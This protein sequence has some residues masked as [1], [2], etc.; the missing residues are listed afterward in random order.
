[1]ENTY[2]GMIGQVGDK[3]NAQ[4]DAVEAWG[5]EQAKLQQ[6]QTDFAIEQ[7]EQQ[8]EQA[9]KDYT[10]EQSAAYTDY[11]KQT[12]QHGVNAEQM[13]AA[14]MTGTGYSES[15]KVS[16]Y[17]TYQNRVA[18]ARES[19]N[20]AVLNYNNSIKE[21]RLRN[22]SVLAEIAFNT[23]QSSLELGLQAFQYEN[24]LV[25]E[26]LG[27]KLDVENMYHGQYMDVLGQINTEKA[28]A[29]EIRQFDIQQQNWQTE[30]DYGKQKDAQDQANWEKQ[31][32]YT[33]EQD[34]IA[35]NNYEREFAHMLEQEA[36]AQK[37]WEAE[38]NQK[39]AAQAREEALDKA[40][41][42]A[43]AGDFSGY[44]AALGLTDA[45]VKKL[46]TQYQNEVKT[47][48]DAE[49]YE[50]QMDRAAVLA[51]AGD[52]SGYKDALGLT[53]AQ[54][55]S[56]EEAY[57]AQNEAGIV[58]DN[59]NPDDTNNEPEELDDETAGM[60]DKVYDA[61]T[62]GAEI[63]D[64]SLK[65]LGYDTASAEELYRLI[66]RGVL[67]C[68]V[69]N[70]KIIFSKGANFIENQGDNVNNRRGVSAGGA[71]DVNVRN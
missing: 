35:Q 55:K 34:A 67:V 1:M 10:K 43:A 24:D 27:I 14:G 60:L 44:K 57:K 28:M 64:L 26:K 9:Q 7:I 63:D 62:N 17:N 29:E 66:E 4:I 65:R 47:A 68:E 42:L 6:E 37:N 15:A 16:M 39:N 61:I 3:Y 71:S 31:F 2:G 46:E 30:F 54:V 32:A 12:A 52:F 45:Q 40:N 53:A 8:K 18:T 56:L 13:A 70:N 36:Q 69:R 58:N 5:N 59:D 41:V 21:A 50:K 25:R 19:Y 11:Q 48:A 22:N 33:Q 38:F 23:L 51:A 20:Q 49:A